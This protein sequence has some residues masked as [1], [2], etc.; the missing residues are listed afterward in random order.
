MPLEILTAAGFLEFLNPENLLEALGTYALVG[1]VLIIFAECGLLVGFFLPGDSLLFA[2]GMFIAQGF[3]PINIW[4]ACLLLTAAAF[5]GNV[6]G[7]WVGAKAG[8]RL[9]ARQDSRIFKQE[10]VDK[11][12]AFFDKYGNRAIVM[13]RFVPIV[14]TFITAMAGVGRMDYRRYLIYSGIGAV[15]WATGVTL[16]GYFLGSIPFVK[17]NV[18][19]MLLAIVFVSAIPMVWEYIKHRRERASESAPD[20]VP[21]DVD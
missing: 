14:R 18:E 20:A 21:A 13:A 9:F 16:L 7:Y 1:V 3:I 8:P 4:W 11:T 19:I 17:N 2:T 12:Q 5:L 10:Y 6:V 15:I